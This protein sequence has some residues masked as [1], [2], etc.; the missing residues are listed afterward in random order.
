VHSTRVEIGAEL[1]HLFVVNDGLKE[2]DRFLLEGLRKVKDDMH[3]QYALLAPDP[4][5]HHLDLYAE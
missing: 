1:Q 4:V 3:V 2:G 5:V